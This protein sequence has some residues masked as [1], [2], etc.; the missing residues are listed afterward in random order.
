ML[1]IGLEEI[2][3]SLSV[4]GFTSLEPRTLL[5]S[6][7]PY[8]QHRMMILILYLASNK[9]YIDNAGIVAVLT[10]VGILATTYHVQDFK[11]FEGDRKIGRKTFPII[12]PVVAR[13]QV[14]VALTLWSAVVSNLWGLNSLVSTIICGLG[15]YTGLRFM[16]MKT[17]YE[18]QT[19]FYWYNVR[20]SAL[21]CLLYPDRSSSGVAYCRQLFARYLAPNF[22]APSGLNF[23]HPSF[24]FLHH[25]II[26]TTQV[27]QQHLIH[28][29]IRSLNSSI[30]LRR[31][32]QSKAICLKI[33]GHSVD[34]HPPVNI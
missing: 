28:H 21:S 25:I 26:I 16:M 7:H 18:D 23:P 10:T 31:K 4:M 29:V 34:S 15:M 1:V 32:I 11:D 3:V 8:L 9:E 14:L 24:L 27:P 33:S 17:M 19:S 30:S 20:S 5:V 6:L 22:P 13:Q 2:R 12:M